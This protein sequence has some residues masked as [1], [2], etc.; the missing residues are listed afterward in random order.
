MK[1]LWRFFF[2]GILGLALGYALT[3]LFHPAAVSRRK[4]NPERRPRRTN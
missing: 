1:A 3:L 2:G 4:A